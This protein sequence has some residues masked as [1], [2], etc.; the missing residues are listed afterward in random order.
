MIYP[1][2]PLAARRIILL[3]GRSELELRLHV[4]SRMVAVA[5]REV[6]YASGGDPDAAYTGGLLHDLGWAVIHG[7]L[8]RTGN[9]LSDEPHDLARVMRVCEHLSVLDFGQVIASGTPAEVR[10]NEAVL[11]AYLGTAP[12]EGDGP[13]ML[14]GD[15]AAE[16]PR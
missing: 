8:A 14:P 7:L 4:R 6:A 11:A 15:P 16:V 2:C 3:R 13:A 10:S 9:A 5:A 12:A 1:A